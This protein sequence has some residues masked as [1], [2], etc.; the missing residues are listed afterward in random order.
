[1]TTKYH[2]FVGIDISKNDFYVAFH[3]DPRCFVYPNTKAGMTKF[4]GEHSEKLKSSLIVLENTG[5]YEY[6]VLSYLCS[7]NLKV[8]RADARKVKNFI[9]S[10]GRRAKTDKI[11]AQAIAHYAA[12]RHAL[13]K[14]YEPLDTLQEELRL[15]E[16]RRIDLKHMIVQEK[17]RAK[18]P[19]K[20]LLKKS[21]E[22]N[23][24]F[25]Q[26]Q[27]REID[28]MLDQR[29]SQNP[30]Y[31]AKKTELMTIPGVGEATAHM[32]LALA[33]ELGTSDRRKIASLMGLAP[34]PQQSGKKT[35]Y[36]RMS[37]GRRSLRPH[38]FLAAMAARRSHSRLAGFYTGLIEKGKKP[39]VAL[40]ALMRK[41]IVIANA[42]LRDL[43]VKQIPQLSA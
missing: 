35:G 2:N 14:L 33:P 16:E 43:N 21:I 3:Q 7:Q 34:H 26:N 4:C 5:G 19:G 24:A 15:L 37:G 42:K 22:D 27:V 38:L 41:I 6:E 25:L 39:L 23:I 28:Q 20:S 32:L 31:Q 40:G 29:I 1:M 12:E 18:A 36:A 11:D 30:D 13:L 8:H 9:R 10:F 17:N